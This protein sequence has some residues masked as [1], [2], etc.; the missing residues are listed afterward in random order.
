MSLGATRG[1]Q[2]FLSSVLQTRPR[3]MI[4]RWFLK[5]R[6][7]KECDLNDTSPYSS[8]FEYSKAVDGLRVAMPSL[9]ILASSGLCSQTL[10]GNLGRLKIKTSRV[11]EAL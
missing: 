5:A 8:A 2:P 9:G 4:G 10:C 11:W 7:K 1:P 6:Q 3:S